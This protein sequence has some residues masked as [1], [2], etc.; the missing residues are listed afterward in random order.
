M[1]DSA[2]ESDASWIFGPEPETFATEKLPDRED[3]ERLRAEKADLD[4]EPEKLF[5]PLE[6]QHEPDTD[7]ASIPVVRPPGADDSL[8]EPGAPGAG[9]VTAPAV[10]VRQPSPGDRVRSGDTPASPPRKSAVT[11]P[12]RFRDVSGWDALRD[13]LVVLCFGAAFVT[14]FT[15]V[16]E[17]LSMLWPRLAAGFG[18]L[19]IVAVYV[20]RWAP[21]YKEGYDPKKPP[22][23]KW[24]GTVRFVG[25]LPAFAVALGTMMYDLVASVP[26]LFT[27]L[28]D[29]PRVGIGA[30][31]ALLL[32][33]A[34]VGAE[35]RGFEGYVPDEKNKRRAALKL[36]ALRIAAFVS[37]AIAVAMMVGKAVNGDFL[38]SLVTLSRTIAAV[39]LVLLVVRPRLNRTPEWYVFLTGVAGAMVLGG[40]ADSTLRLDYAAEASFSNAYVWL[41]FLFLAFGVLISR[42][43][44]RSAPVR[45]ERSDWIV[46]AARTFEFSIVMHA[47]AL[48]VALVYLVAIL[49]GYPGPSGYIFAICRVVLLVLLFVLS[50]IARRCLDLTDSTKARS[51]A[52]SAG[53]GLAVLGFVGIVVYSIADGD[54]ASLTNGGLALVVGIVASL[55]LTVPT[56]ERDEYGAPDLARTFAHFRERNSRVP[57]MVPFLPDTS[58]DTATRKSFPG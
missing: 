7:T 15:E 57:S 14:S 53:V 58:R 1:P 32:L 4:R 51:H 17:A 45:F 48:V 20:L 33:G 27:P 56:P 46:Y 25:M 55:M 19:A 29:G 47:V 43:Y 9:S 2:P 12:P 21:T 28:P 24:L 6:R 26:D 34:T 40:A 38:F 22:Y 41:P 3:F 18:I 37:L 39:A 54:A 31:V 52:V 5:A 49:A 30:G 11:L 16:P 13:L 23:L 50:V 8:S 44:V 35:R 36:Q 42:A 10:P